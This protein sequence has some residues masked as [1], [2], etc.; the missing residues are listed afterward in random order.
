MPHITVAFVSREE[1]RRDRA[2]AGSLGLLHA[3][4]APGHDPAAGDTAVGRAYIAELG[5][6][7]DGS[8]HLNYS[9]CHDRY[10]RTPDRWKFTERVYE[11]IYL[12]TTALAGSAPHAA[13]SAQRPT[14]RCTCPKPP[15]R[16]ASAT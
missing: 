8:S 7:R 1:I 14:G 16:S 4:R 12:D 3:D 9:I 2:A 10:Q 11:V 15:P 5:R 6:L 13:G